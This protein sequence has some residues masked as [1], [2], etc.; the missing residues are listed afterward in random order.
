MSVPAARALRP[1]PLTREAFAPFGTVVET[2]GATAIPI[3]QGTTMRY[4]ALAEADPGPDGRA[5]LSIFVAM[6]R[7]TPVAITMLERHPLG[8]QAFMPLA[9]R[10]WLVV[11]AEAPETAQLRCF[12]AT[13]YQGVQYKRGV[14]HHPLLVLEPHHAFLVVDRAGPGQN[15]EERS[16]S[17]GALVQGV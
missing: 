10:D 7:P 16:L 14:W 8:G 2:A 4:H 5:I 1:E 11:V 12:R 6:P 3:N 15:L 17:P 9:A 13:G